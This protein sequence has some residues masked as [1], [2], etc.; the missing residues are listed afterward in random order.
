MAPVVQELNKYPN[1]I[2]S[3]VCVTAQHRQM[4]DQALNLFYITPDFDLNL[5]RSKQT[6]S[7]LTASLIQKLEP[8]MSQVQPDWVLVQGDTTTVMAAALVAFYHRVK[9]GH[10]LY[11]DGQAARRVV[12]A[13]LKQS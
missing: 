9:I 8:V 13:L 3:V 7:Q 10:N 6:L 12:R 11:G 2:R 5:M 4:L 1:Q